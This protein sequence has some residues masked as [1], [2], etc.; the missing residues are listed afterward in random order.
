MQSK[1]KQYLLS[2]KSYIELKKTFMNQMDYSSLIFILAKVSDHD[3]VDKIIN[4]IQMMNYGKVSLMIDN[5]LYDNH[6]YSPL[7]EAYDIKQFDFDYINNVTIDEIKDRIGVERINLYKI[8]DDAGNTL[9]YLKHWENDER[10]SIVIHEQLIYKIK[11]N[12]NTNLNVKKELICANLGYY[13]KFTIN[14]AGKGKEYVN[15]DFID[16]NDD[17]YMFGDHRYDKSENPYIDFFGEGDEAN[18]AYSNKN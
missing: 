2:I 3:F 18:D 14:E 8:K 16:W 10:F 6:E 17:P 5:Y 11:N 15:D 12:P 1:D 9:Q 4:E 13:T 7:F